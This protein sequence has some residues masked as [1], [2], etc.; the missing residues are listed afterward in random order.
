M[1]ERA[2]NSLSICF[3]VT[4]WRWLVCKKKKRSNTSRFTTSC[5]RSDLILHNIFWDKYCTP[6]AEPCIKTHVVHIGKLQDGNTYAFKAAVSD[7]WSSCGRWINQDCTS[8]ADPWRKAHVQP[9]GELLCRT[10]LGR[11][12]GYYCLNQ[13]TYVRTEITPASMIEHG[14]GATQ[15]CN[16]HYAHYRYDQQ[17]KTAGQLL[18]RPPERKTTLLSEHICSSFNLKILLSPSHPKSWIDGCWRDVKRD[19]PTV[20]SK[21][22]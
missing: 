7:G 17:V 1:N 5:H 11:V 21:R 10:K 9:I 18:K 4:I 22:V 14:L 12:Q 3:G 6:C 13:N 20:A 2:L 16:E 8:C 19:P 15:N